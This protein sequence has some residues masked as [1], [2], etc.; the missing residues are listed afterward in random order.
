MDKTNKLYLS[1]VKR[2]FGWPINES[3]KKVIWRKLKNHSKNGKTIN[4]KKL[5]EKEIKECKR[6]IDFIKNHISIEFDRT[7]T[8]GYLRKTKIG[9]S[10]QFFCSK[11]PNCNSR[12]LI[13]INITNNKVNLSC[14]QLCK[15]SLSAEPSIY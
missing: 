5:N 15:H 6:I 11:N 13:R 12:W 14:N 3:L 7:T 9:Y 1:K 8:F 10:V 4:L 2:H